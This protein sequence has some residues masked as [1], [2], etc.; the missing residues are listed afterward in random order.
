MVV[1]CFWGESW[2]PVVLWRGLPQFSCDLKKPPGVAT[3]SRSSVKKFYFFEKSS[4]ILFSFTWK[5]V[6]V[7]VR[8]PFLQ[9]LYL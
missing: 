9:G 2:T 6:L 3:K 7:Q 8:E 1:G 5:M 4:P